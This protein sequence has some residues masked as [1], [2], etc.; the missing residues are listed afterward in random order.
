MPI[1]L[2][3]ETN[4]F[5]V[6]KKNEEQKTIHFT[7]H[8]VG[9]Y[10]KLYSILRKKHNYHLHT[11]TIRDITGRVLMNGNFF[12]IF[13]EL[14]TQLTTEHKFVI[15][16][17]NS[18][19]GEILHW[20]D[21][22]AGVLEQLKVLQEKYKFS[23]D[24]RLFNKLKVIN[25]STRDNHY[26]ILDNLIEIFTPKEVVQSE[27]SVHLNFEEVLVEMRPLILNGTDKEKIEAKAILA[28]V[29]QKLAEK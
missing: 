4:T 5:T 29:A 26:D 22:E 20:R 13:S 9:L 7:G 16:D 15:A 24:A 8:R 10:Y 18:D 23:G 25:N 2:F 21:D 27:L 19:G 28:Y 12:D 1:P 14:V 6:Y 17:K 11:A 3:H